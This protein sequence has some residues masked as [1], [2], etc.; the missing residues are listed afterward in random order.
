MIRCVRIWTGADGNS[1][2][3]EGSIALLRGERGDILGDK[4]GATSISYRETSS[5]GAFAPHDAPVRQFVLTLSGT[6]EFRCADGA[7][8][9]IYPG[10]VLLAEDTTGSGHSWRLVD[11]QP[12]RRA[13]II[14]G[15]NTDAGF[16]KH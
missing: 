10:D 1:R 5:G 14:L 12:W 4:L 15:A 9:L 16:V 8:F 13:Y 3:E 7:T 11:D 2:F 6:L